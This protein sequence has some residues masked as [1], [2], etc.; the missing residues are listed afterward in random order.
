MSALITSLSPAFRFLER[1]RPAVA[2]DT[3][4]TPDSLF[5]PLHREFGFT[6][7]VAADASN[8]KCERFFT[9]RDNALVRSW[10][11]NNCWCNHPWSQTPA[12]VEKCW[13]ESLAG[14][15]LCV[16][17]LPDNRTHQRFWSTLV[18]PFRETI[19]AGVK[20][21]VRFLPGRPHFGTPADPLAKR[22]KH[23]KHGCALLIW[24]RVDDEA[25]VQFFEQRQLELL[26]P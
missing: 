21:R 3:R 8:A 2:T 12:W 22:K 5:A 10:G 20:L 9:E 25:P 24:R 14:T 16:M 23:P 4:L 13:R 17:L 19:F 26:S 1:V 11:V 6:L 18:E 15:P 7:D